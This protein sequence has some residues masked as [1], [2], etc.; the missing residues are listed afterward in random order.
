MKLIFDENMFKDA[1]T[2]MD[3]DVKKMPLGKLSKGQI[4]KG[5]KV[6]VRVF[7]LVNTCVCVRAC[8]F[9]VSFYITMCSCVCVCVLACV[10]ACMRAC[11]RAF[12]AFSCR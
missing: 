11:V 10:F 12:G 1:M 3:V 6:R 8:A 9:L 4:E 2:K 5:Y 7:W